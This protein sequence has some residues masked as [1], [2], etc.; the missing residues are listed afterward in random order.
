[1]LKDTHPTIA[2]P[3]LLRVLIDEHQMSWDDPWAI[4]IISFAYTK[5]TLMPE[6]LERWYVKL[7]KGLLPRHIHIINEITTRFKSLVEKT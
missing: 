5:H 6:S 2:I 3:G 4:T 7:F 1:Q